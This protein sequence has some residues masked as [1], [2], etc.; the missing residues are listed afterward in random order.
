MNE[1]MRASAADDVDSISLHAWLHARTAHLNAA[2]RDGI[3]L[4]Q[5]LNINLIQTPGVEARIPVCDYLLLLLWFRIVEQD[6]Q[7]EAIELSFRQ[8][9]CAF[10]LNRVFRCQDCK[11]WRQQM[12]FA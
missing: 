7:Q 11:N 4:S 12:S 3:R 5:R 1:R 8:G 10:I 9:V 6:F 2:A